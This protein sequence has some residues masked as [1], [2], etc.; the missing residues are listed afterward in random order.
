MTTALTPTYTP[1]FSSPDFI[2]RA[3]D[4]RL[5]LEVQYAGAVVAVVSGTLTL[6]DPSNVAVLSAVA[7]SVTSA[8]VPYYDL[9]AASVPASYS[10]SQRWLEDWTLT[11]SDGQVHT[12]RRSAHLVLRRLYPCVT[13]GDLTRRHHDLAQLIPTGQTL[14]GYLDDAWDTVILRLIK[15]SRY[16][17]QIMTPEGLVEAHKALALSRAYRDTQLG[18]G[19]DGKYGSLADF[20][21]TAYENEWPTMKFTI[22]LDEDNGPPGDDEEGIGGQPVIFLGGAPRS[23]R[24][25]GTP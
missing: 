13:V 2:E 5:S 9:L 19:G 15:D 11:F 24:S 4:Q 25:T 6:R 7:V 17:Q 21:N 22:D 23:W 1:R 12:F 20:Y 3:K 18:E 8:G 10:P 16:P 14:Q